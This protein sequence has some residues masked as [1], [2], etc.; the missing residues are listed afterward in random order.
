MSKTIAVFYNPDKPNIKNIHAHLIQWLK[1]QGVQVITKLS[2]GD[3]RCAEFALVLGG[4]GTILRVARTLAPH[5]IPIL[6]INLGRL[7]F[8]AETDI[9]DLYKILKKALNQ[10]LKIEDRDMLKIS[11][12]RG[13]K[14]KRA[15]TEILDNLVKSSL[16]L[17]DCYIHTGSSSRIIELDAY[18]NGE[19]LATYIGDGLIISTPTGSTAYS[20]AA[21]GPIV[22]PQL[23]VMLLTPICPHTLAQRPLLVS[24][25]D[26]VELVI[27]N[28]ALSKFIFLS[29]DGQESVS[30]QLK[31][32]IRIENASQKLKLLVDPK[33]SYYQILRTK[34]RW[35][36]R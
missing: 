8:L 6:G 17:N 31:D 12:F 14:N 11:V 30:I 9:K 24:S 21:S 3:L 36:E 34:L 16:A 13:G 18:V 35:G 26:H 15:K 28:C 32:R 1:K 29:F 7:G 20:L 33:R 10:E 2:H 4:D 23:P 5:G 25:Q 19:F 27:K 22:V